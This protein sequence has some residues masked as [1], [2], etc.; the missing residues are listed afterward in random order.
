MPPTSSDKSPAVEPKQAKLH[1]TQKL[2]ANYMI[3]IDFAFTN[4][5]AAP[6][7]H[8]GTWAKAEESI[9]NQRVRG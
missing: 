5:Q 4:I 1:S 7:R 9:F 6:S 8:K 2:S 3:G